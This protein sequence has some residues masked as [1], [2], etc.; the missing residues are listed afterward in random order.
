MVELNHAQ[1][2]LETAGGRAAT[3]VKGARWVNGVLGNVKRAISGCDHA[4]RQAKYARRDRAE[5]ADR[6]N[7]RFRLA[8][9]LPRLARARVLCKPPKTKPRAATTV[10][11]ADKI[12]MSYSYLWMR[13]VVSVSGATLLR[14]MV[15]SRW[16][17]GHEFRKLISR[18]V[19]RIQVAHDLGHLLDTMSLVTASAGLTF[20][21]R[22]AERIDHAPGPGPG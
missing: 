7:R 20:R 21:A 4:L 1:T 9:L 13:S 17:L 16:F 14:G 11:R 2:V 15:T 22:L 5:A 8:E 18:Y 12:S 10:A 3:E 6:F 19:C